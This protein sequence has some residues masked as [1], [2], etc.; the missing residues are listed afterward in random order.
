MFSLSGVE[1]RVHIII[2]LANTEKENERRAAPIYLVKLG[3]DESK[4][5][6][7]KNLLKSCDP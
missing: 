3:Y 7:H 6:P 1:E 2:H 4:L 5:A